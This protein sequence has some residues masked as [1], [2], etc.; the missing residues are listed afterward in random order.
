ML[1]GKI[2]FHCSY[3]KEKKK[4]EKKR[5]KGRKRE[6]PTFVWKLFLEKK[7]ISYFYTENKNKNKNEVKIRDKI[8][9]GL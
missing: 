4:K 7:L 1:N 3:Q 9:S 2:T 5:E 6:K 8:F